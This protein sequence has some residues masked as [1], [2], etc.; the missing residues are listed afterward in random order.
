[1]SQGAAAAVCGQHP[2]PINATNAMT[3]TISQSHRQHRG[4]R[5]TTDGLDGDPI[6]SARDT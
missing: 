3:A 6:R 4:C 1:M 5:G 2:I